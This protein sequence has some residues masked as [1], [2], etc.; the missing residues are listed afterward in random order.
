VHVENVDELDVTSLGT[1]T[2][3]L[4]RIATALADPVSAQRDSRAR[5]SLRA[6]P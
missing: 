1:L 4:E 5:A 6:L 3:S 2:R